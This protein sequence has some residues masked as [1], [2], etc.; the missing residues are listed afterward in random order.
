MNSVA[1]ILG[2]EMRKKIKTALYKLGCCIQWTA[3][4][5]NEI[6]DNEEIDL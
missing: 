2:P 3:P 6:V 4:S 1:Y 5:H